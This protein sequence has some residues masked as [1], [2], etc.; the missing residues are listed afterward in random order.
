MPTDAERLDELE[1]QMELV[2]ALLV[3]AFQ[4]IELLDKII[5]PQA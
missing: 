3:E 5:T 1:E 4:R 2:S